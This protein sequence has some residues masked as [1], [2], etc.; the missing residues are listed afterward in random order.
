MKKIFK[1]FYP[2]N[3]KE[4][5]DLWEKCIF[6][7]DA[8][9]LLNLYR[10]SQR[11]SKQLRKILNND[12]IKNRIWI[13]YQFAKEYQTQRLKVIN[14]QKC[15]Y[16]KLILDIDKLIKNHK[17]HSFVNIDSLMKAVKVK[18]VDKQKKH[19]EWNIDDS[20]RDELTR[21]FDGKVGE[22]FHF[23]SDEDKKNKYKNWQERYL[24]KIPPGYE[25]IKKPEEERY[26]DLIG[27]LEIMDYARD[28]KKSIIFIT[29][30]NTEDWWW[31]INGW[32]I[33]P[34]YELRKE[35]INEAQSLFYM[36]NSKE[37]MQH[38]SEYL[39]QK[40]DKFVVAELEEVNK[41]ICIEDEATGSDSVGVQETEGNAES[42]KPFD[43]SV[44]Q[45]GDVGK[46]NP[47]SE[48]K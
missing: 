23:F 41:K 33:G 12:K 36:Y 25:D 27:W 37:F 45:K 34:R 30:D 28:N 22:P 48:I 21:I 15:F 14:E 6:I 32:T 20:I 11:T 18:I 46:S 13:P 29:D 17:R 10:Y 24:K 35:I 16:E 7:F 9:V 43:A 44:I 5:K 40:V 1:E 39:K 3:D 47:S 26:G 8:N 4:L 19:P 38:T 42:I 31:R 2:L